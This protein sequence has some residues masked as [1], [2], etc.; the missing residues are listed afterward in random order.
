MLPLLLG[1]D[2][3]Y[4]FSCAP[5][6]SP[7]ACGG[8]KGLALALPAVGPADDAQA[9]ADLRPHVLRHRCRLARLLPSGTADYVGR[10]EVVERDVFRAGRSARPETPCAEDAGHAGEGG[11][12]LGVI[13]SVEFGLGLR[14]R[15][16][17]DQQQP[18]GTLRREPI[19]GQDLLALEAQQPLAP[20]RHPLRPGRQVLA[21][22]RAISFALQH[23]DAIEIVSRDRVLGVL[24]AD[25]ALTAQKPGHALPLGNMLEIVPIVEL[26]FGDIRKIHRRDQLTLWHGFLLF[27]NFHFS[28]RRGRLLR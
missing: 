22:D 9:V 13:P 6:P 12:V 2:R 10:G 26:V 5:Y 3:Q 20:R 19:A 28:W 7:R 15:G 16:H 25:P 23:F 1:A 27:V 14:W 24:G 21:A 11:N 4:P 18:A 17:P 8:G